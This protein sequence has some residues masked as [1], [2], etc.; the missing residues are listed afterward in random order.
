MKNEDLD[1]TKPIQPV[2]EGLSRE[3]KFED[4]LE[5]EIGSRE[6]KY[7]KMLEEEKSK[8]AEEEAEKALA[9]KNIELAEEYEKE[10]IEAEEQKEIL[11]ATKDEDKEKKK[12]KPLVRFKN[13]WKSLDKMQKI[14]YG[15][16]GALF[17]ILL[18]LLLVGVI[19][20]I[21]KKKPDDKPKDEAPIQEEAA[22]IMYDNYYYKDG[23]LYFLS[24]G[25]SDIGSYTCEN[26]SEKLCAVATNNYRDGLDVPNLAKENGEEIVEHVKIVA[27]DFVFINDTDTEG[28]NNIILYSIKKNE[29]IA[30]YTDVKA[31]DNGYY[32]VKDASDKYGLIQIDTEKKD[33]IKPQ[34]SYLGMIDGENYLVAKEAKGYIIIDKKDKA[35]SKYINVGEVK[36]YNSNFIV[37]KNNG[38]YGVYDYKGK[39]L[40]SGA[41]FITVKGKYIFEVNEGR[42]FVYDASDNKFTEDGVELHNTEYVKTFVYDD[43]DQLVTVKRSFETE[44][45]AS[46]ITIGVYNATFEDPQ[47]SN[48]S[49]PEGNLNKNY[50]FVNYFDGTLY[51]YSNEEK[52]DL[53]GSYTCASK[54]EVTG[55][56]KEFSNCYLAK[57]TVFEDN[58]TTTSAMKSR[59]AMTPIISNKYVFIKDG[60]NNI[61]LYDLVAR[62]N[63]S[64]YNRVNTYTANNDY[65]VTS[66]SGKVEIAALNKKGKYGVIRVVDGNVSPLYAFNY[67]KIE[68]LGNYFIGLDTAGKWLIFANGKT[69]GV[70]DEKVAG[71]NS[72][73]S[74]VKTFNKEYYAVYSFAG[75]KIVG[76]LH[77]VELF[78]DCFVRVDDDKNIA[79][80]DYSGKKLSESVQAF[81]SVNVKSYDKQLIKLKKTSE[82]YVV[83][84]YNGKEY[85]DTTL[86]FVTEHHEEQG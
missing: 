42:I 72:D 69:V 78:D 13:W 31:Y 19:A 11:E 57:D 76:G 22:P 84:V 29:K 82:G 64:S 27:D 83:S 73:L 74:Y 41:I 58:V 7:Q 36:Y 24:E 43:N 18:I 2:G 77:Y 15:I 39:Q 32:A 71:Y 21:S 53:L 49:I 6:E 50:K 1:S 47:Y 9:Q 75:D 46:E 48:L 12:E 23:A 54:N 14:I 30:N 60:D 80:Y 35:I 66:I 62:T 70:Y 40:R 17:L 16:I 33:V 25:G 44:V 59:K 20:L 67:N 26:K 55:S 81:S 63:K 45:K 28:K 56:S 61:V 38:T 65:K 79:V 51:F 34:Y 68:K 86:P 4:V 85:K 10:E 8:E 52:T 5:E 37:T 3:E